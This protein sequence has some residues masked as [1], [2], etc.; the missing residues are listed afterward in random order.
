[1]K[2]ND[3]VEKYLNEPDRLRLR[4]VQRHK[5]ESF[6]NANKRYPQDYLFDMVYTPEGEIFWGKLYR[7][8]YDTKTN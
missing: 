3:F 8:L 5:P 2:I 1:M 6:W 4:Y 7:F